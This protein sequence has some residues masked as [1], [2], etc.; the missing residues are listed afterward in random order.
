MFEKILDP[1]A[2]AFSIVLISLS[3]DRISESII[4]PGKGVVFSSVL[5]GV[6]K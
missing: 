2:N 1:V 6:T 4:R 5:G 3:I